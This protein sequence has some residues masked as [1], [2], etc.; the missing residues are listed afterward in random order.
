ML[1]FSLLSLNRM[2]IMFLNRVH[3]RDIDVP[4]LLELLDT[5]KYMGIG[6]LLCCAGN[7]ISKIGINELGPVQV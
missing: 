1:D 7:L 3:A 5:V 2:G 4:S 6:V